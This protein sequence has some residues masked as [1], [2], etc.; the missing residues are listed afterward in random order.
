VRGVL[1]AVDFVLHDRSGGRDGD[2]S[3]HEEEVGALP[4]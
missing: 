2:E 1:V 3:L 4:C